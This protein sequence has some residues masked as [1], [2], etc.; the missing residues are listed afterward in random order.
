MTEF[1][2]LLFCDCRCIQG[3]LSGILLFF[4][5]FLIHGPLVCTLLLFVKVCPLGLRYVNPFDLTQRPRLGNLLCFSNDITYT[6]YFYFSFFIVLSLFSPL[7]Y[8][9]LLFNIL[10]NSIFTL[11]VYR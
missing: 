5:G 10:R 6:T 8:V 4:Y 3:L 2:N 7:L 1:E 9:L 11:K